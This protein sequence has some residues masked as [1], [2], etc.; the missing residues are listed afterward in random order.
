[1]LDISWELYDKIVTKPF[2]VQRYED[3]SYMSGMRE[4]REVQIQKQIDSSA[5]FFSRSSL[6]LVTIKAIIPKCGFAPGEKINIDVSVDNQTSADMENVLISLQYIENY[7]CQ[8]PWAKLEEKIS[9]KISE[10]IAEGVKAGFTKK[11]K[12]SVLVPENSKITSVMFTNVFQIAYHVQITA[13]FRR[14]GINLCIPVYIGTVALRPEDSE[15]NY[16]T[17]FAPL[18][19]PEENDNN[20]EDVKNGGALVKE[21]TDSASAVT[22]DVAANE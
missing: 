11:I 6:G 21:D 9:T 10:T 1:M 20:D 14:A 2:I 19:P 16:T 3:L 22:V 13:K 4:P 8:T 5:W 7:A 18:W 12:E 15:H 17:A